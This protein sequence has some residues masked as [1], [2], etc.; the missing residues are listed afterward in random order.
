MD[1]AEVLKSLI[2]WGPGSVI[3]AFIIYVLYRLA[4][5]LG[6]K[7]IE[8]QLQQADALARQAQSMERLQV[9]IQAFVT[10]DNNEHREMIILLKVVAD[11]QE[12]IAKKVDAFKERKNGSQERE[13]QAY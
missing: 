3:A 12:T 13:I 7:F 8:A 5:S 11:G 2:F 1:F 10:R 4:N 6:L 9:S